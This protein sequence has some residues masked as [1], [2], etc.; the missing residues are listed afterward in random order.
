M[1]WQYDDGG[2]AAAGFKGTTRDCGV[3]AVAIA[4]GTPYAAVYAALATLHAKRTGKRTCRDGLMPET[5]T[6]YLAPM[7]WRWVPCMRVGSGCTVHLDEL[8]RGR[9][10]ARVSKHFIAVVD[11]VARDDHDSTRG[12]RRC[13]YGYWINEA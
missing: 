13:V 4:T 12:G 6:E 3:R 11:G 9:V 2:R 8:P 10:I 5:I 7:G 1:D